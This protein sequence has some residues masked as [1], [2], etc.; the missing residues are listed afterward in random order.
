MMQ[1]NFLAIIVCAVVSMIVGTIWYGPL[2]GKKWM[3][4]FNFT[5]EEME[6]GKKDMP[7]TYGMMFAGTLATSYVLAVIVGMAPMHDMITGVVG[8]FW[9]WLGF[10][11]A[12]KFSE[13]LFEKKSLEVF[14]IESGYYFVFL[15]VAGAILGSW[16]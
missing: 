14:Y 8:A 1:V 5:K 2:F 16:A 15:L 9:V 11:V 4:H 3:K 7:K 6:K 12:V 10:I 13:V